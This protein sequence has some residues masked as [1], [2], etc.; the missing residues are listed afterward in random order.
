MKAYLIYEKLWYSVVLV[1]PM[2]TEPSEE[3]KSEKNSMTLA[4]ISLTLTISLLFMQHDKMYV[5]MS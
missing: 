5:K 3:A 4:T 1:I 2:K